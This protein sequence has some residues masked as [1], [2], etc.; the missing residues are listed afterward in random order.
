MAAATATSDRDAAA[1]RRASRADSASAARASVPAAS[2]RR[3]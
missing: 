2:R 3:V 1:V